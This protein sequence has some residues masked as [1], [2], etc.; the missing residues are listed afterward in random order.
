M[1]QTYPS[2]HL[3][4]NSFALAVEEEAA[5][6]F[7]LIMKAEGTDFIKDAG[8]EEKMHAAADG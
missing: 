1:C 2:I 3:D 6:L 5:H 8:V 7:G 4:I